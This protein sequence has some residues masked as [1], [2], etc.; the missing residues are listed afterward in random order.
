MS[1]DIEKNYYKLKSDEFN[2]HINNLK[3]WLGH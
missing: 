3:N 1:E 2:L